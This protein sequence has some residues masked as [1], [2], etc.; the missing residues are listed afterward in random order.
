MLDGLQSLRNGM[1]NAQAKE[2]R[3]FWNKVTKPF[4]VKVWFFKSFFYKVKVK[5]IVDYVTIATFLKL[6]YFI[7]YFFDLKHEGFLFDFVIS[8]FAQNETNY[9]I[10][11]QILHYLAM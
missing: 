1:F 6:I 4:T 3:K 7:F 2:H 10:D 5:C 9:F 8:K 11:I